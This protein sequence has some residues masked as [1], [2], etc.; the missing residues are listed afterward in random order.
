MY[1]DSEISG[2]VKVA[3]RTSYAVLKA[4]GEN[5]LTYLQSQIT[6]D[7]RQLNEKQAIY[8][9]LLNPQAKAISDLYLLQAGNGELIIIVPSQQA[10]AVVERLRRFM[11][12]FQ[13]RIG[14]VSA[15]QLISVQGEGV[16]DYLRANQLPV[17]DKT[18]LAAN[19]GEGIWVLRMPESAADGVWLVSEERGVACNADDS[20]M[21]HGRIL[22]GEP[23]FG[24]DWDEK[25]LPLNAN[26]IERGGVS[27]DK[28]CYVGQEVTSR[29]R[30]RGGIR[31]KLYRVHVAGVIQSL[32]CAVHSS[33]VAV[34]SITSVAVND[35]GEQFG[36]ALLPIEVAEANK[37]LST[38]CGGKVTVLGTCAREN[39]T[40][41]M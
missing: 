3:R 30:W 31:K 10:I 20:M 11:L 19:A 23:M 2:E 21:D 29:M 4:S 32:P 28:G 37:T 5:L 38:A 33:T 7:I 41:K 25:V 34:G 9:A 14:M 18:L 13:L 26:L 35:E 39:Q 1:P 36:I 17:P 27:F 12:G 8:A 16:D 6:Q 40:N 15:L 24:V 22:K